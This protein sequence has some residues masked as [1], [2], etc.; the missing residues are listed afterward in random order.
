VVVSSVLL[1]GQGLIYSY[2]SI[3]AH[4]SEAGGRRRR[5]ERSYHTGSG[6]EPE[7]VPVIVAAV[8][9]PVVLAEEVVFFGARARGA[10]GRT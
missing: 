6:P 1:L 5:N 9:V 8:S 2:Q 3:D 10:E 7:E 4:V